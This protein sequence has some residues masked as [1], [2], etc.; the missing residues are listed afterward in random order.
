[1]CYLYS[2]LGL[3]TEQQCRELGQDGRRD[4]LER[5]MTPWNEGSKARIVRG[6]D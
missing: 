5:T 1:M 2:L 3:G 6:A 4:N